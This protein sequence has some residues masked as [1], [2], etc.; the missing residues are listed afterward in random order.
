MLLK[1]LSGIRFS[2]TGYIQ[3]AIVYDYETNTDL[4]DGC[5]VEYAIAHY[6]DRTIKRITAEGSKL[7]LTI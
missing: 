7:I 2:I 3:E 1:E 5:S 4:V 6:G